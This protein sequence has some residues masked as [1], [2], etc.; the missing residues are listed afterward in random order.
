MVAWKTGEELRNPDSSAFL[1][2]ATPTPA[3]ILYRATPKSTSRLGHRA[4]AWDI[5]HAYHKA[6]LLGRALPRSSSVALPTTVHYRGSRRDR[7]ILRARAQEGAT[8]SYQ[9]G[10]TMRVKPKREEGT[11]VYVNREGVTLI[12]TRGRRN[13]RLR[14]RGR[15]DLSQP[16]RQARSVLLGG[17]HDSM[18]GRCNQS[19]VRS[20]KV[21]PTKWEGATE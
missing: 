8:A 11:A 5:G 3:S 2:R 19:N 17:K 13:Q 6:V 7:M 9:C 15:Y 4:C 21:Q 18:N 14:L 16:V 1:F 20:E 10:S 12:A